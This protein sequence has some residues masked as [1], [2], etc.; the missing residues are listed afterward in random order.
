MPTQPG[1][2][3]TSPFGNGAGNVGESRMA[4]NNFL[5]N[6]SG[7]GGSGRGRDFLREPVPSQSP[8]ESGA[9]R[10]TDDAASGGLVPKVQAAPGPDVGAGSIGNGAKPFRLGGGGA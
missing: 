8:R 6:P 7:G 5:T 3:S 4:G 1:N 2:G 10:S 9:D